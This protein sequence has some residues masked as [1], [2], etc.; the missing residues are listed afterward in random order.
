MDKISPQ[1]FY[2]FMVSQ[3]ISQ[4]VNPQNITFDRLPGRWVFWDGVPL[5]DLLTFCRIFLPLY[6]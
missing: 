3:R 1:K 5:V 6:P 4:F 2:S